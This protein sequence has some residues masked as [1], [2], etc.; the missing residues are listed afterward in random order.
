MIEA[1]RAGV[2]GQGFNVVATEVRRLAAQTADFA[3]EIGG[4]LG[5][6][7]KGV[8]DVAGSTRAPGE[9]I[10]RASGVVAEP[11]TVNESVGDANQRMGEA[12]RRSAEDA[13]RGRETAA[14]LVETAEGDSRLIGELERTPGAS[15]PIETVGTGIAESREEGAPWSAKCRIF[16]RI[17]GGI[18]P[19]AQILSSA[20]FWRRRRAA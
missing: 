20:T 15:R 7:Q 11:R 16:D 8:D 3:G 9:S 4:I 2:H 19:I 5:G 14:K 13:E 12:I 18:R 1:A 10:G 6:V 17:S